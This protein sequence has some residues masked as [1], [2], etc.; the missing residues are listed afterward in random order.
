MV[1]SDGLSPFDSG[2]RAGRL[3]V[4][5]RVRR[6]RLFRVRHRTI[7]RL[8]GEDATECAKQKSRRVE[9]GI[10]DN[11]GPRALHFSSGGAEDIARRGP[12]RSGRRRRSIVPELLFSDDGDATDA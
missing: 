8:A 2:F 4:P 11:A 5:T 6:R 1:L 3:R 7:S 10:I 9:A 12:A